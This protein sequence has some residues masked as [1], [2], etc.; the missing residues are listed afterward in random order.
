M[1]FLTILFGLVLVVECYK[2]HWQINNRK[3]AYAAEYIDTF[4]HCSGSI[5][6]T[7]TNVQVSFVFSLDD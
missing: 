6:L 1:R 7:V 5:N 2:R 3:I 4:A